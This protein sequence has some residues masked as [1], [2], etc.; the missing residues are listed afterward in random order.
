MNH[1]YIRFCIDHPEI[2]QWWSAEK[3]GVGDRFVIAG[4]GILGTIVSVAVIPRG[5][6]WVL[7]IKS[8]RENYRS[9]DQNPFD[10]GWYIFLPSIVHI[11]HL[12]R[13][14]VITSKQME[15]MI[16]LFGFDGKRKKWVYDDKPWHM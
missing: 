3:R 12:Y 6:V 10:K 5:Y 1:E 4:T 13:D 16:R 2:Q 7:D 15:Q 8:E 11:M 9:C 14:E